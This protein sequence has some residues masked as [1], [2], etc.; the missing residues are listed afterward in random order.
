MRKSIDHVNH[1]AADAGADA[2]DEVFDAIH[3]VMHLYRSPRHREAGADAPE[4]THMEHKV[5]GF[6]ARHPGATQSELALHSGRDKGQL[7]RLIGGLRDRGL[8]E[9][10]ADAQD[11]RN[12]RLHVTAAA[13][14]VQQAAQCQARRVAATAVTGLSAAERKQLLALLQRVRANLEPPA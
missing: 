6:F 5:L 10:R 12:L 2:A 1:V 9:A 13:T 11:R 4:L 14:A 7:A 3:T 8:L